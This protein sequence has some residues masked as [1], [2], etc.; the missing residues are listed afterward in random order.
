MSREKLL[1]LLLFLSFFFITPALGRIIPDGTSLSLESE[2]LK[3]EQLSGLIVIGIFLIIIVVMLWERKTKTFSF[4][5]GMVIFILIIILLFILP[6]FIPYPEHPKVPEEW[7]ANKIDFPSEIKPF[8]KAAGIP[9]EWLS[10]PTFLY[11]FLIPFVAIWVIVYAFL[12]QIKIFGEETK[13]Y[14]VLSFLVTLSTIPLGFFIKIVAVIFAFAGGILFEFGAA[15][16]RGCTSG[17]ALSGM[18]VL[19][20]GGFV[21]MLTIFGGA[22]AFAYFARKLWI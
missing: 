22:Y 7:E 4:P 10:M 12:K 19:A 8:F 11:F 13:W 9:E 2:Q 15:L 6:I 1:F 3:S 14:R 16:A 21:T 20:T 17:A 18:A 5:I